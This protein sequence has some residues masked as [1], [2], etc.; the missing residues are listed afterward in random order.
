MVLTKREKIIA[1]ATLGIVALL[2]VDRY[3]A[4]PYFAL[5]A[6]LQRRTTEARLELTRDRRLL[7]NRA[8]VADAWRALLA[9]GLKTDPG[10]AESG[11][12]HALLAYAHDA[13]V[14]IQSLKPDRATRS[15]DFQQIRIQVAGRGTTATAALFMWRIEKAKM[16][17]RI[18]AIQF[19]PSPEGTD[20]LT[21]QMDIATLVL[22]PP[23][24]RQSPGG[25]V[26]G[27]EAPS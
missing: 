12:L 4:T 8:R 16:P 9:G 25:A 7:K 22:T 3:V 19:V 10:A 2:V 18:L 23:G 5:S 15:G 24:R 13:G 20:H 21:F 17:L 27:G 14:S 26:R 6:R 11:V 1:A